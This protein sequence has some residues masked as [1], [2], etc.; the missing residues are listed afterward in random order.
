MPDK[1]PI[2]QVSV[3]LDDLDGRLYFTALDTLPPKCLSLEIY[4][5]KINSMNQFNYFRGIIWVDSHTF[6]LNKCSTSFQ[7]CINEYLVDLRDVICIPHLKDVHY[8]TL[9]E[10]N[11]CFRTI[12]KNLELNQEQKNCGCFLT[13]FKMGSQKGLPYQLFPCNFHKRRN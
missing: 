11:N 8:W 5:R 7:R 6:W 12:N 9:A 13:L 4:K 3:I 10:W 2:S 1:M